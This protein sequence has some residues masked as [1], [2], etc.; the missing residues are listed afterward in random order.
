M[1]SSRR[2][3]GFVLRRSCCTQNHTCPPRRWPKIVPITIV[4]EE[5]GG[6]ESAIAALV[7]GFVVLIGVVGYESSSNFLSCSGSSRSSRRDVLRRFLVEIVSGAGGAGDVGV[8]LKQGRRN[9]R[10]ASTFGIF[11]D[12]K[13]QTK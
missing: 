5:R 9:R 11:L 4:L 3:E 1:E 6:A 2:S 7:V 13:L 10:R 12:R 8:E